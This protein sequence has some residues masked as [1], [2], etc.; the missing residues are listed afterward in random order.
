MAGEFA[1]SQFSGLPVDLARRPGGDG[2]KDGHIFLGYSYDIKSAKKPGN[3][4]HE[5]GKPFADIFVLAKYENGA[6]V[7]LGW[8]WG[9]VLQRAPVKDFGY[10]VINHYIPAEKM[11]PMDSLRARMLRLGVCR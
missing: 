5:Q 7:L 11:R 3:L 2:G 9:H 4:I 10:G 6:A 1:F 8:E